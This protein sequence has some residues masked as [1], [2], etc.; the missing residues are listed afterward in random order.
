MDNVNLCIVSLR[1]GE[2][3]WESP[4]LRGTSER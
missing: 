1:Y 4:V 3:A 2:V